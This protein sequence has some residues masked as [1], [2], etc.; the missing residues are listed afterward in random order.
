MPTVSLPAADA[1][2]RDELVGFAY[3]GLEGAAEAVK[4]AIEGAPR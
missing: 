2:R 4:D 1:V 3:H